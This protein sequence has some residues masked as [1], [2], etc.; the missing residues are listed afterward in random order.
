MNRRQFLAG[1]AAAV[2]VTALKSTSAIVAPTIGVDVAPGQSQTVV[3]LLGQD[4][5][6]SW[7]PLYTTLF[8]SGEHNWL[9]RLE[10]DVSDPARCD[11]DLRD[12]GIAIT[13]RTERGVEWIDPFHFI[14]SDEM[15][16]DLHQVRA[17]ESADRPLRPEFRDL[18]LQQ[19]PLPETGE[20]T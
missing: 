19:W 3:T 13:R 12:Y 2:S 9:D 8:E 17:A 4:G 18:Y 10:A 7:S 6:R 20:E 1:A 15:R 5:Y 11:D 16:S 14:P